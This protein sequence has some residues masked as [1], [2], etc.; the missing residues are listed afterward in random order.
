MTN[1]PTIEPVPGT[2][3]YLPPRGHYL[4]HEVGRLAGVSGQRSASGLAGYIRSSQSDG[5]PRVYSDQDVAEAMVVDEL[6]DRGVPYAGIRETIQSLRERSGNA[7]P[8]THAWIGTVGTRVVGEAADGFIDLSNIPWHG[9]A[10]ERD[11]VRSHRIRPAARR[12]GG[13]R[14]ASA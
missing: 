3:H 12:L 2:L 5:P 9:L 8:L 6:R 14:A 13:Q 11:D 4:A 7:W 1:E 10:I